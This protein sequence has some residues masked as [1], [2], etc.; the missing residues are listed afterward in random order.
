MAITGLV[1][2]RAAEVG[3]NG[4]Q[5]AFHVGDAMQAN[6]TVTMAEGS[7]YANNRRKEHKQKFDSGSL[8]LG[9]DD[10]IDTVQVKML[11][12]RTKSVTVDSSTVTVNVSN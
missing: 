11:G 8:E 4:F 12:H 3:E 5:N 2:E 1:G 6:L 7:L 10:L 9:V